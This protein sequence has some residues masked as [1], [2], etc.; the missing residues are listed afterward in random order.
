MKVFKSSNCLKGEKSSSF[1]FVELFEV[2][3]ED[4][5]CQSFISDEGLIYSDT[6]HLNKAECLYFFDKSKELCNSLISK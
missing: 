1:Y 6:H 2:F 3:C 5:K 4:G